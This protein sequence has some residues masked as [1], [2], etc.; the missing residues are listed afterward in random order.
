MLS[1][2]RTMHAVVFSF[3]ATFDM[4]PKISAMAAGAEVSVYHDL[5][6]ITQT[7]IAEFYLASVAGAV[8][9]IRADD[10]HLAIRDFLRR[11]KAFLRREHLWK[12]A[13]YFLL[14]H[15]KL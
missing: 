6:H 1:L 3:G 14:S 7:G 11:C 8:R 13:E 5:A 12:L 2:N 4:A 10:Y 15:A 9:G